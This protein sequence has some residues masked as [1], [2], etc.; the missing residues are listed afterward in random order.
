MNEVIVLWHNNLRFASEDR[1]KVYLKRIGR[2]QGI[3]GDFAKKNAYDLLEAAQRIVDR[4]V[5]L[6]TSKKK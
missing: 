6:W 4:G 3:K 2:S 5:F 1:L